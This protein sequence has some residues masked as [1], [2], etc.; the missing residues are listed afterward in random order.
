METKRACKLGF[1]CFTNIQHHQ[2]HLLRTQ[3]MQNIPVTK[4][5]NFRIYNVDSAI[6]ML[7]NEASAHIGD[8]VQTRSASI[9]QFPDF[10]V[11]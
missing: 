3:T 4:T 5:L 6:V 7:P 8:M 10:R 2:S 9:E 1:I 11:P